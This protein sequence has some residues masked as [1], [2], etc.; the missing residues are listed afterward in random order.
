MHNLIFPKSL[1]NGHPK[2]DIANNTMWCR[3]C[4][5][6]DDDDDVLISVLSRTALDL[7]KG[8]FIGMELILGSYFWKQN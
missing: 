7:E 4:D 3:T 6:D 8:D 2:K 5:D 1:Q